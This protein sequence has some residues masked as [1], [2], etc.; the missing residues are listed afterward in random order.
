M[1]ATAGAPGAWS[2]VTQSMPLITPEVDP[3]PPQSSTRTATRVTCLATPHAVVHA[4]VGGRPG[5]GRRRQPGAEAEQ[6]VLEHALH[7]PPAAGE[8]AGHRGDAGSGPGRRPAMPSHA[9]L[10][11]HE[12]LVPDRLFRAA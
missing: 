6:G 11:D 10:E 12:V 5:G 8:V 1:L 3:L 2:P 4:G 7:G 9:R